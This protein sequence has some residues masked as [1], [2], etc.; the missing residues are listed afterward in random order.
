MYYIYLSPSTQKN[1]DGAVDGY[2]EETV[3]NRI[4][5]EMVNIFMTYPQIKVYRNK[6][7]MTLTDII[8]D[9]NSKYLDAH[10]AIHSNA[11]GGSGCEIWA[12][13]AGINGDKLAKSIYKYLSELTPNSDRGVKYGNYIENTRVKAASCIVEVEF[14]DNAEIAKWILANIKNIATALVKGIL[15]YLKVPYVVK[16]LKVGAKVQLTK[17]PLYLTSYGG[18][19]VRYITG[20]YTV[21]RIISNRTAGV[22]L[23]TNM[24]WVRASDCVVI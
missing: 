7:G 2:V 19:P 14:H 8:N 17:A 22:L 23:N 3:M 5:D 10:I 13:K 6:P 12:T 18:K 16:V 9:S 15:E 4:A 24:G 1:N 21:S 11:G 20:T